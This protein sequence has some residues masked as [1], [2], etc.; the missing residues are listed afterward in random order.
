M[1][2]EIRRVPS[3]W[4]HPRYTAEDTT[5]RDTVGE[6]RPLLDGDYE[7]EKAEWLENLAAWEAGTHPDRSRPDAPPEYWDWSGSPPSRS[8]YVPYSSADA[9]WFQLYETV[10]EGTP[11]SPPFTTKDELVEW[12]ASNPDFWGYRRSLEQA[13]W[14]VEKEWAPSAV[15]FVPSA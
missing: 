6:Y 7:A 2:R 11:L 15:I 4:E 9:T 5:R 1:G 12:L 3:R 8:E 10:S 14:I 13:R